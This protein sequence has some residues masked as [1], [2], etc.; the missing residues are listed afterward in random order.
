MGGRGA[1]F[2]GACR[3]LSLGRDHELIPRRARLAGRVRCRRR[4]RPKPVGL[5]RIG[6][7]PRPTKARRRPRR[8][9]RPRG[10]VR[11]RP[12]R[13][14]GESGHR[15]AKQDGSRYARSKPRTTRTAPHRHF[16]LTRCRRSGPLGSTGFWA[17]FWDIRPSPGGRPRVRITVDRA[18]PEAV[19]GD[20]RGGG[21]VLWR[22]GQG[23]MLL[24]VLSE[25]DHFSGVGSSLVCRWRS[26]G[27]R[28]GRQSLQ[29]TS[30]SM[31]E[32]GVGVGTTPL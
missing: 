11:P 13:C 17:S 20:V 26:G 4:T 1:G 6:P 15:R 32:I 30:A 12:A 31:I 2:R 14:P 29:G 21:C 22:S 19:D 18:R 3:L 25:G 24:R 16:G 10:S 7:G 23:G 28:S 9:F 5:P 27:A 8:P